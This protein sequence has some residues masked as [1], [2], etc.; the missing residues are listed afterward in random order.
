MFRVVLKFFGANANAP[1]VSWVYQNSQPLIHPFEG[2]FPTVGSRGAFTIEI[3]ALIALL[4]FA[5]ISRLIQS[6]VQGLHSSAAKTT[7]KSKSED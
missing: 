6:F 1:F 3:S 2:I 7:S 5:L 4:V